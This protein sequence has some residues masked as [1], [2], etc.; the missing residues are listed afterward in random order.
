MDKGLE[1]DIGHRLVNSTYLI[2]TEFARQDDTFEPQVSQASHLLGRAV[3]ALGRSVKTYRRKV[4]VQQM[5]ILDDECIDTYVVEVLDHLE[6]LSVLVIMEEGVECD[7]HLHAVG[8]G[9]VDDLR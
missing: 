7:Q 6:R 5:E 8:V 3:V 4:E 9:I 1:L 2:D